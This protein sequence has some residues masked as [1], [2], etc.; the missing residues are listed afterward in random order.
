MSTRAFVSQSLNNHFPGKG[1]IAE[2]ILFEIVQETQ[3]GWDFFPFRKE[4]MRLANSLLQNCN[5]N[6]NLKSIL[7]KS[8]DFAGTFREL[9]VPGDPRLWEP[10]LWPLAYEEE[11][12][13]KEVDDG[14][15]RCRKCKSMKT[16]YTELQTRSCDEPTSVFV[17]CTNCGNRWKFSG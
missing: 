6:G 5:R 1:D 4:Y 10:S 12:V 16:T 3:Q 8:L 15:F 9:V 17:N 11:I 2:N 14:I 13:A 7:E